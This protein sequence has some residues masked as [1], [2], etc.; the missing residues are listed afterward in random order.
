ST[1][2]APQPHAELIFVMHGQ[3]RK[4]KT[5]VLG[6]PKKINECVECHS[7]CVLLKCFLAKTS[8]N[9]LTLSWRPNAISIT[10][11]LRKWKRKIHIIITG[12]NL[13][14]TILKV[15]PLAKDWDL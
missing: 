2:K 12:Y 5:R 8:T 3:R 6:K 11:I 9:D 10:N 15:R 13:E 1:N 14:L 7:E 4:K